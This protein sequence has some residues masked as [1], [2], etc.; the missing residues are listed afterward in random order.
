MSRRALGIIAVVTLVACR[1]SHSTDPAAVRHVIDS[2]NTK[3]EQWYAAGQ[4]DSLVQNFADDVWQMPPNSAPLVGRDSVRAFWS[5]LMQ[6]GQV[7]FD[8]EIA[9]LVVADSIA[10]ERGR[11][12]LK[13]AALPQ[14]RI[15]S[16]E[17][18]GNY[19]AMWRREAD[20]HWRIVWDA[21]VSV[22]SPTAPPLN[23]PAAR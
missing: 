21:P 1:S 13:F 5:G 19:V 17:D 18:E 12:T 2:L 9:D 7:T 23:G 20:G 8:L 10:V 16:F 3:A 14:S 6:G 4:I 22:R 15:A 11:Y